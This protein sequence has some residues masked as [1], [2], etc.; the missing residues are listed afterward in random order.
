MLA[1]ARDNVRAPDARALSMGGN[2]AT[3]TPLLNPAL[4]AL[5]ER[6][7]LRVDYYNRYAM[8]ELATISGG[9]CFP[10]E[11]LPVGLHVASFGYDEYR[12]S[13]FRFS[14]GK[15]LNAYWSLGVSVQYVLLQSELFEADMSRLSTDIGA[16]FRPVENWLIT[17]SLVNIPS[18]SLNGENGRSELIAPYSIEMGMNWQVINTLLITGGAAHDKETPWKASLG[19]EYLPYTHFHFRAGVR[20]SPFCPSLGFGYLLAGLTTDIV[21]IYHPVLGLSS[22]VGMAYTF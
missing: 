9:F 2:G 21:L 17:M 16:T 8:Q 6:K 22:G 5:K 18:F 10:N 13:L 15:R 12:E 14:T 7:E 4:L 3:H 1:E 19:M 20:T 11:I